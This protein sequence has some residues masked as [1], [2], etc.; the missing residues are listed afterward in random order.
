MFLKIKFFTINKSLLYFHVRKHK[1]EKS[2]LV[3]SE[4]KEQALN[5]AL[6]KLA[7]KNYEKRKQG[8]ITIEK[9]I[10]EISI[11]EAG[12]QNQKDVQLKSDNTDI[13]TSMSKS[14]LPQSSGQQKIM[15]TINLLINSFIRS[16]EV[17]HRKGGLIALAG[18]ALGLGK[19]IAIY[20]DVLLPAVYSLSQDPDVRVRYYVS[21]SLYNIIKV[22]TDSILKHFDFIFQGF[23]D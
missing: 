9:F 2:Y 5:Y 19:N 13:M 20:L 4:T 8:A 12:I 16:N 15:Q 1:K 6:I 14:I 18:V 17:N 3:N 23:V 10:R 22:A 21:E 7:D 11:T